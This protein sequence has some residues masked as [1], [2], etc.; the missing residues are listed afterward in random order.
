[1]VHCSQVI[2]A[3]WVSRS[4]WTFTVFVSVALPFVVLSDVKAQLPSQEPGPF[5]GNL[6]CGPRCVQRVLEHYGKKSDLLELIGQ[7]QWP[8]FEQ[9]SSMAALAKA[10]EARG[11]HTRAVNLDSDSEINWDRPVIVHLG[12]QTLGHYTVW[13]PQQN[14]S[15]TPRLWDA[16]NNPVIGLTRFDE[17]RSGPVLLT[18]DEPIADSRIVGRRRQTIYRGALLISTLTCSVVCGALMYGWYRH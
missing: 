9:G 15:T 12:T 4:S 17:L 8:A 16:S 1:M 11:L 13:L 14:G 2:S 7:M 3:A 5:D 18:S 10:L 6:F